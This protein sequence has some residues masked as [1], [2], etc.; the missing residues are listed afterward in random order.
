M[1]EYLNKY[2]YAWMLVLSIEML[3]SV[4]AVDMLPKV[5]AL[6]RSFHFRKKSQVALKKPINARCILTELL[7]QDFAA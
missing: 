6:V 3:V 1:I 7:G 2:R 4:S 5:I